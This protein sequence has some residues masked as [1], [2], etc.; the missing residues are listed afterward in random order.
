MISVVEAPS[1]NA[2]AGKG[3]RPFDTGRRK[4]GAL[5]GDG[6][7]VG[8]NSVFN[9]GSIGQRR[10]KPAEKLKATREMFLR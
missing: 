8:C 2:L 3:R 9:P 5:V 7:E 10:R 6:A 1:G 4:F